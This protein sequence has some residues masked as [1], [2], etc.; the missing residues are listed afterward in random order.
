MQDTQSQKLTEQDNRFLNFIEQVWYTNG[1]LP[2]REK[3]KEFGFHDEFWNKLRTNDLYRKQ[4]VARGIRRDILD[5]YKDGERD[6]HLLTEEQLTAANVWLDLRD[7]RSQR[8]KLEELGIPTAIWESWLQ[9]PAF[10][11]YLSTRAERMLGYNIH[12]ANLALMAKVRS[13]DVNAIKFYYELSGHYLTP[14]QKKAV[15]ETKLVEKQLNATDFDVRALLTRIVEA[16]QKYVDNPA[17]QQ[18]IADDIMAFVRASVSE[19]LNPTVPL[20]IPQAVVNL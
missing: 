6:R 14:H 18:A 16:I 19:P 12:E 15:A 8:K 7:N 1:S 2:S 17:V 4:L 10:Q 11:N 13:G 3:I 20:A 9:D 5:A